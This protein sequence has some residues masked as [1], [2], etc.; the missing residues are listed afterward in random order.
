MRISDVFNRPITNVPG[1]HVE[2]LQRTS[3]DNNET[4]EYNGKTSTLLNLSSYNYLGFAQATGPCAEAVQEAVAKYGIS[5]G[6]PRA[7]GGTHVL[8]KEAERLV[9]RFLG[10]EDALIVS[11]GFAT[12]STTIPALVSKGCLIISDELNHKSL[13]YGARVSGASIKVFKHNGFV[14]LI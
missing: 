3:H 2:V 6:A 9:A 14:V 11:M 10:K 13:V 8:H 7:D 12:N 5:T 4:F 1:R